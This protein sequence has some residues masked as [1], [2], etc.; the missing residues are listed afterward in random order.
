MRRIIAERGAGDIVYV[1]ESGFA[2]HPYRPGGWGRRGQKVYGDRWG[3]RGARTSLIAA[4][5]GKALLAPVLFEGTADTAL[6]N[7][8]FETQLIPILRVHSTVIWD[9]ATFHNKDALRA[10]AAASTHQVLF[11]P[12]YSPDFNKIEHDFAIIKKQRLY[13]PP[14][15]PID[16]IIKMYICCSE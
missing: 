1:D 10:L 6:V 11:L 12:P 13:H 14:D 2:P 9:N 4:R 16:D 5:R 15:T 7:Y 3:K 8:W